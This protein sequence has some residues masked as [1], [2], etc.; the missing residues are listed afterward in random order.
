VFEYGKVLLTIATIIGVFFS[1]AVFVADPARRILSAIFFKPAIVVES[2]R[3][4]RSARIRND[5]GRSVFLTR[6]EVEI[7]LPAIEGDDLVPDQ[8][9]IRSFDLIEQEIPPGRSVQMELLSLEARRALRLDGSGT[10]S[11]VPSINVDE[12]RYIHQYRDDTLSHL[13]RILFY[14]EEDPELISRVSNS[15]LR[16]ALPSGVCTIFY[17]VEY[18]RKERSEEFGCRAIAA[19][20]GE[21]QTAIKEYYQWKNGSSDG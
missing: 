19:F 3:T 17:T 9:I 8:Q 1:G 6:Y 13:G 4:E 15:T 10:I 7:K 16:E 18:S 12:F 11:P 2:F 5:A 14:S 20:I 21:L